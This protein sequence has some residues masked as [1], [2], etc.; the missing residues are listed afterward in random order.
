[1][2]NGLEDIPPPE[3]DDDAGEGEASEDEAPATTTRGRRRQLRVRKQDELLA[4]GG[5]PWTY[6]EQNPPEIIF[7]GEGIGRHYGSMRKIA[8]EILRYAKL[9]EALV[10]TEPNME[11]L[12]FEDSVHIRLRPDAT[13]TARMNG[14]IERAKDLARQFEK[15][16]SKRLE[17]EIQRA[18]RASIPDVTVGVAMAA[19]LLSARVEDTPRQAVELGASVAA[20]YKAL[21]DSLARENASIEIRNV[22]NRTDSVVLST[23]RAERVAD[24]LRTISEPQRFEEVLVGI[25][26][27][28]D[29]TQRGFGL[30]LDKDAPRPEWIGPR[31][32][33][34]R[35]AYLRDVGETIRDNGYWGKR[36]RATIRVERDSLVSNSRIRAP[37]YTLVGVTEAVN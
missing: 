34:I 4:A 20:E 32:R 24:V 15:K 7:T 23:A 19:D 27:I 21:A 25:L 33:I 36:V 8:T 30:L 37:S 22:P 16:P 26:S 5:D 10:G 18:R 1:M 13:E 11:R 35:G 12:A 31:T 2:G 3:P 9:H 6:Y 28:A 29:A 17:R 14:E